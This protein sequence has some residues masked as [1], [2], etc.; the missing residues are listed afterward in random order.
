MKRAELTALCDRIKIKD[1]EHLWRIVI[2]EWAY[3]EANGPVLF[4]IEWQKRRRDVDSKQMSWGKGGRY[5]LEE[6][7]TPSQVVLRLF[8]ALLAYDEHELREHFLLDGR[9]VLGPH[10]M[11]T[12]DWTAS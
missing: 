4:A 7:A 8:K 2:T 9:A 12:E 3:V 1:Q 11:L 10:P 6:D 5:M